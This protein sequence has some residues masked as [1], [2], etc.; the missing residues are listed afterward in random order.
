MVPDMH[1]FGRMNEYMSQKVWSVE[2]TPFCGTKLDHPGWPALPLGT[3]VAQHS[4]PKT[5]RDA[6]GVHCAMMESWL[7][8]SQHEKMR[9]A[10]DMCYI[11]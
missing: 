9:F 2:H 6:N 11:L 4:C 7:S 8:M 10:C 3:M 1:L 5:L